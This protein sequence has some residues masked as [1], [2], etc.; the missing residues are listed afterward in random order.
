M[1]KTVFLFSGQGSQYP[2]MAQELTAASKS[3]AEV[4]SC[5]S[6][7]LGLDLKKIC[8]TGTAQEL[9]ATTVA[10]PAI[11]ATS[12]A[13]LCCVRGAGIQA[14]AVA[15]HSLG[16]YAAMVA[17]G[18]LSMEDGFRLIGHRAAAMGKCAAEH[19]GSMAAILGLS[20][21]EVEKVCRET[22]GYVL[23][24]N[25][26]STAQT[27]IAGEKAAVAA[28]CETFAAMGKRAVPLAVAAAF[29]SGLMQP[30]ADEFYE[31]AKAFTFAPPKMDFYANLTGE[32]LTDFS[33][34]PGYLARHIVSP[35]RFTAELAAL[36]AA[37][38][39][40]YLELGPGKVLTGLVKKTLKG[41]EAM[42][43]ENQKTL[44][45]VTG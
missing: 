32:K 45:K 18:M 23:P 43:I 19:P 28:A 2:G 10:Q 17:S 4:F 36:Q 27:V 33:D 31:A 12:L 7:V 15:G 14:E 11:M 26:N 6:D 20:A 24:V 44:E 16:E 22:E 5:A 8:E 39:D 40:R 25:F 37:G 13:A 34:M 9:A 3:A 29:H 1:S 35:V 30:A 21:E 38:F 41:V 42:N